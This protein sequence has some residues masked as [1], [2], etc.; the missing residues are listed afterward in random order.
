V[1]GI[2]ILSVNVPS[3]IAREDYGMLACTDWWARTDAGIS[4][5]IRGRVRRERGTRTANLR[6]TS[7]DSVQ[8]QIDLRARLSAVAARD[9]W[10]HD[11]ARFEVAAGPRVF[12]VR[13]VKGYATIWHWVG[14]ADQIVD[15]VENWSAR[16]RVGALA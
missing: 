10:A 2:P 8:A 5:S 12:D 4:S 13:C 6:Y 15:A 14:T 1:S 3:A 7:S 11:D 9:G 16:R